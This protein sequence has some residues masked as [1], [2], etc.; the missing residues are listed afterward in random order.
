ME[1][2]V[3]ASMRTLVD[4]IPEVVS[5]IALD[6][7]FLF[8]SAGARTLYGR[9]PDQLVGTSALDLIDPAHHADS[10]A[11]LRALGEGE[12]VEV[13]ITVRILRPDG[14]SIWAEI[15]G[16][17]VRDSDSGELEIVSVAREATERVK[18]ES[19]LAAYESRFRDMVE[20]L[21]AIVY[22]AEPGPD[23][24]FLYVSPQIEETLGYTP[25]E[26][27]ARP[28]MWRE[29]LHPDERDRVLAL[30]AEQE[31]RSLESD[32]RLASEYRMVHRSGREVWVRDIA[33][34]CRGDD[35]SLFW[36]GVLIDISAERGAQVALADA[37]ERHRGMIDSMP[38]CSY[39]AERR[40]MGQWQFVSAQIEHLLGYT[41]EEWL[42]DPT[43]WRASLHAD[44]RERV[45]LEEQR[46]MELP[47][48][49]EVVTEYR[50]RHRSGRLVAVRDRAI[51]TAGPD[52]EHLIE[53]ILTDISAERAAEAVAD[54]LDDVYRLSCGDCGKTW[55]AERIARCPQ[56]SSQNVES[57]SLNGT[58]QELAASRQQVEGLLDGIQKHLD[59]LGTNLGS[60][61]AQMMAT[62]ERPQG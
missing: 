12:G 18:V 56:C 7:R 3:E 54:G 16:H 40:A 37:H 8:V 45:E 33:R 47:A 57:V 23:G 19:A 2:S 9:D 4:G 46:Q 17:S 38:A 13:R 20:W 27:L 41:P 52:G 62:E 5:L 35:D 30:E 14:D 28:E 49:T 6:G 61:S 34:V 39:R 44:D 11:K 48:G 36:R 43:L 15:L 51:L 24:R 25:D 10:L 31:R 53:G 29:R 60:I 1:H 50:L 32:A 26:W 42:A 58:L 55:A 22:E 21:P 59:A